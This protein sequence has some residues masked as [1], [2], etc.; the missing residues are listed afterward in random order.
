VTYRGDDR[1]PERFW[2]KVA[3]NPSTDCWEWTASLNADGYGWFRLGSRTDATQR[4]R[5]AHRLAYEALVGEV[6]GGFHVDH[7]CDNRACVN[8]AHL[9]AVTPRVNVLRSASHVAEN[10][11]K[12]RCAAGHHFD[13]AN[14]YRRPCG[15]RTCRTCRRDSK[16]R[17]RAGAV[18]K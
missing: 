11:L 2:S 5:M 4:S 3:P 12:M 1:L 17:S 9:E 7:L 10:E 18:A 15:S 13:E 8:P 14:T 16:R 6:P